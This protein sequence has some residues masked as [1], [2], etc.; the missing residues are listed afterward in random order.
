MDVSLTPEVMA[1][2]VIFLSILA[3][4]WL[5]YQRSLDRRNQHSLFGLVDPKTVPRTKNFVHSWETSGVMT[6][7]R[8]ATT[9]ALRK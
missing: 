3:K 7:R 8:F 6:I 1:I 9:L 4:I 2:F 5:S